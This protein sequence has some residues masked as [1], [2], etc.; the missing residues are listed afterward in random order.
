MSPMKKKLC[1]M[2][3]ELCDMYDS[4]DSTSMLAEL[5]EQAICNT[6]RTLEYLPRGKLYG[7]NKARSIHRGHEYNVP[8]RNRAAN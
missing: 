3:D 1:E 8:E 7:N 6:V 4:L 5:T 2:L